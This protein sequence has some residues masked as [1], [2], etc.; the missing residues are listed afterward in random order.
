[1]G[2]GPL[3]GLLLTAGLRVCRAQSMTSVENIAC[4]HFRGRQQRLQ[5]S[6]DKAVAGLYG[7]GFVARP[8]RGIVEFSCA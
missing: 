2:A 1:M 7:E 5:R 4:S 6:A 8:P 3:N